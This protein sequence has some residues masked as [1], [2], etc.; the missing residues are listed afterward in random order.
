MIS[1]KSADD[2][3]QRSR[4]EEVLLLESQQLAGI[5]VVVGI[6]DLRDVLAVVLILAGFVITAFVERDKVKALFRFRLIVSL[7]RF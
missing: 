5:G 1:L 3:L 2:I 6:K 7:F 4:G